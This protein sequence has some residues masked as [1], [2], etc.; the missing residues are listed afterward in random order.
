VGTTADWRRAL[1]DRPELICD[2][3][4]GWESADQAFLEN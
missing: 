3:T 2:V 1:R 4:A